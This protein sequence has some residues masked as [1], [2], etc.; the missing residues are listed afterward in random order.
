MMLILLAGCAKTA[1]VPLH[2][3]SYC[4]SGTVPDVAAL[5]RVA[6]YV[7]DGTQYKSP[8]G[9]FSARP[10]R[11][12]EKYGGIVGSWNPGDFDLPKTVEDARRVGFEPFALAVPDDGAVKGNPRILFLAFRSVKDANR[13]IWTPQAS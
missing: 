9:P 13:V 1:P 10:K 6:A 12:L 11:A 4:K 5:R 8:S 7:E 3:E 2:Y